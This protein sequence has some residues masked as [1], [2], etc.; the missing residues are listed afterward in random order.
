LVSQIG[1]ASQLDAY[2]DALRLS[3]RQGVGMV[4]FREP[5][6]AALP[7]PDAQAALRHAYEQVLAVCREAAVPCMVNSVHPREWW[8]EAAGVQLRAADARQA[9]RDT[10]GLRQDALLGVSAHNADDLACAGA[11]QAD[12]AVLGHVLP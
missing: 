8:N 7:D 2:L 9:Q 10:L 3:L 5:G 12:F 11:L 4:Q 1:Q 6:W